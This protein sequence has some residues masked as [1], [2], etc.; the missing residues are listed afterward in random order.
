MVEE[1]CLDS[2]S[3][4]GEPVAA[5]GE[6]ERTE[7]PVSVSLQFFTVYTGIKGGKIGKAC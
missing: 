1:L 2:D 6:A 4:G 5:E 7:Q 3:M